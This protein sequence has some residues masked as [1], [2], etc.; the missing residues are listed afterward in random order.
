MKIAVLGAGPMGLAVAYRLVQCGYSPVLFESSDRVGGMT[1]TFD[2][3][4]INIERF[5]HFHCTSDGYFLNLLKE[6]KIDN[7]MVWR[8]TKM[9]YWYNNKLQDWGNP[10]ALL[11]FDGVSLMS[12]FRYGLHA[13]LCVK[14][15][16]W[17]SIE[18][19]NASKWIKNWVGQEAYTVFW[20][21]LFKYK[22]F[23]YG[24]ELSSSWILARIRRIGRSRYNIFREKLGYLIGGSQTFLDAITVFIKNNGGLIR[25]NTPVTK[26]LVNKGTVYGI[27]I[28]NKTEYFD[29]VISTIPLPYIPKIIPDLPEYILKKINLID[30]M[31]VVCIIVKLKKKLSHNFWLNIND[32]GMDIPGLVEYSNLCQMNENI[33]YVPFYIHGDN[34]K[35]N[36]SDKVFIGKVC[37]YLKIINKNILDDDIIDVC[38]NRYKYAQPICVP[39]F[40]S[41]LPPV[42]VFT[43]LWIADTSY[44][45]PEDRGIS[46]SIGFGFKLADLAII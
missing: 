14:K 39:N 13:F 42:S 5:Y 2:F 29:K 34:P 25:L 19:V 18:S 40:L 1:S 36:D 31:A 24:G 21:K 11:S 16:N 35:Y 26:V 17:N 7:K 43:N 15:N 23:G 46:E 3:G 44:Y 45:Y 22:F 33:I 20:D 6:L 27:L 37:R 8:E 9:G 28:E 30:N 32:E 10:F 4:G 38:V 12:K 41:K